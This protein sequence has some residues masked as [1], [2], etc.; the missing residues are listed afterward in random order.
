[1]KQTTVK[2]LESELWIGNTVSE[3]VHYG[4][5]FPVHRESD[6]M[7]LADVWKYKNE[8]GLKSWD[9]EDVA[10]AM[11]AVRNKKISY[12]QLPSHVL[13]R[14]P[15]GVPESTPAR[16]LLKPFSHNWGVSRFS[17]IS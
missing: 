14:V 12:L 7:L 3:I 5:L 1:M 11:T 8:T 9:N 6:T 10:K 15:H 16:T 13:F 17:S 2:A 4:V